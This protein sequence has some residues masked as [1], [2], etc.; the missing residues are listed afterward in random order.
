MSTPTTDCDVLVVGAGLAGLKAARELTAAGKRV[1]VLEARDRVGGRS[2][3]GEICGHTIDLGGQWVGPD[4]KRLLAEAAALGVNTCPQYVEGDSLLHFDGKRRRYAS[5]IPPL[6]PLALLEIALLERRWRREAGSLPV[7][8]AWS[9]P[10]AAQWDSESV[11]SWMRKHVRT[12]DARQFLRVVTRALLCAEPEQVSYLCMLEY[13]RQGKDLRTLLDVTG[14]AQQD[15]FVGGAWQIPKRMA[16]QLGQCITLNSPV[17]GI[18]QHADAVTVHTAQ[19]DYRAT[20]VIIAT[21]PALAAKIDY[22]QPLPSRRWGLLQRMPMG[23]VIKIHVA[24][25]T[26]F[27]RQRGL[28]GAVASNDRIFNVVFD[29]TPA[30]QSIGILVGFMDGAHA[31]EMSTRGEQ[32]RRDQVIADL[33]SYFGDDAAQPIGYVD[34]DWTQEAWSLGGYVA[35]MPPGVMTQYGPSLR[36]PCGRIHWAGTETATQWCGY[37]D[38]ALQSGQR[39]AE[40]ILGG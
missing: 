14:G 25:P 10:Q 9:A 3:P 23:A 18:D 39:A 31:V 13:M 2:K 40:E 33:V 21:P 27:W 38:G 19:A 16:D 37:L 12:R 1:R 6:S 20:Q 4:Q 35:H 34:Q 22:N 32:A 36:E 29:Q 24:Y 30:D 5:D 17:L 8:A 15:K 28:N 26:A 7:G 11:A